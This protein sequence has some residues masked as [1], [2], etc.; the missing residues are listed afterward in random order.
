MV[1]GFQSLAAHKK[2]EQ[3]YIKS[4]PCGKDLSLSGAVPLR[5]SAI[6]FS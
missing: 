4:P 6:F 1:A 5:L 3:A 2:R